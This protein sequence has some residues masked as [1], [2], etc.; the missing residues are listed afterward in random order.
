MRLKSKLRRVLLP[1][2]LVIGAM[3][4]S[5]SGAQAW[6]IY[7]TYHYGDFPLNAGETYRIGIGNAH[8][9]T[10][11]NIA[12]Y[13]GSGNVS[14][15]QRTYDHTAGVYREGCGTNTA[16]NALNLTPY[17]EHLLEPG[18]KNNSG[19]LHTIDGYYYRGSP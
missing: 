7:E 6:T 15:C 11:G 9:D 10:V 5:A 13:E 17:Y 2:G 16:G 12:K 4:V 14:V 18:I 8:Y 3:A 19:F 1:L